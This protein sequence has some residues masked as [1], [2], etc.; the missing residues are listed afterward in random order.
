MNKYIQDTHAHVLIWLEEAA[1]MIRESFTEQLIIE[2]KS[3][4]SDLVTNMDKSVQNFFI[5]KIMEYYPTHQILGE[6]SAEQFKDTNR[7]HVWVIDPI[8][9]TA[10]FVK[11]QDHFCIL[12][13]YYEND[14]GK[15]GYIYDVMNK[16]L[17]YAI[18]NAGVFLNNS[19]LPTP[20]AISLQEGLVSID[21][22]NWYGKASLERLAT[23]AFDIR[24]FGC[25]GIDSIHV[26][27]GKF[28]AFA[29]SIAGPWDIAAQRIFAKE[30]GLCVSKFDGSDVNYLKGGNWV[31]SNKAAYE[32][33][34]TIVKEF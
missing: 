32:D 28:A 33:L 31:I 21:V 3:N 17:Y 1:N 26:I 13:S 4:F 6:E 9:G 5:Q 7:E 15:L 20:P 14:I 18:E 11:Q 27:T 24:Y 22:R 16:N 30:L 25:G 19:K 8:D 12:I 23:E 2:T 34:L 29:A 10:N